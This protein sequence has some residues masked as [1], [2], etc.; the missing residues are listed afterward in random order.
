MHGLLGRLGRK[1]VDCPGAL[2]LPP[3]GDNWAI[4]GL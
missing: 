2:S 4:I 3:L 1:K